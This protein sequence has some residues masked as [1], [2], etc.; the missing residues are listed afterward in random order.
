MQYNTHIFVSN[1]Y[2][3]KAIFNNGGGLASAAPISRPRTRMMPQFNASTS[4]SMTQPAPESSSVS[5]PVLSSLA[6]SRSTLTSS[7]TTS[8]QIAANKSNAY[9]QYQRSRRSSMFNRTNLPTEEESATMGPAPTKTASASAIITSPTSPITSTRLPLLNKI[10]E[11]KNDFSSYRRGAK[12]SSVQDQQTAVTP[13]ASVSTTAAPAASIP[14]H[15]T[16]I[17]SSPPPPITAPK[18]TDVSAAIEPKP[19]KRR[20]VKKP[21]KECGQHVCKKDYRGLK[22]HTGEV[23]C[24]HSYCLFCAKCHQNFNGLE[25]CTD[26]KNFYHTEV[27]SIKSF[28]LH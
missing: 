17:S 21:C 22:I 20:V 6:T 16:E 5:T 15:N 3:K 27:I 24:F 9:F 2:G 1:R 8:S 28:F 26:G 18:A 25:F 11:E 4:T 10:S 23:F 19:R 14:K 12:S 7:S 13:T